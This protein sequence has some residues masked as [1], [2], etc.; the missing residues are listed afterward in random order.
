M[1]G[2]G[3]EDDA[4]EK[5]HEA[6]PR[7]IEKAREQGDLPR[8]Q[9]AQTFAAYVGFAVA[10]AIAGGW[11]AEGLGVAKKARPYRPLR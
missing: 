4:Q 1:A 2:E 8:S 10:V 11:M 3:G 5:T 7:K 9:D 6:T